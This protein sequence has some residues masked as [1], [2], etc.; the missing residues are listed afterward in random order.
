MIKEKIHVIIGGALLMSDE[1][2]VRAKF[3]DERLKFAQD[4]SFKILVGIRVLIA[5][6]NRECRGHGT[7][8]GAIFDFVATSLEESV[9]SM[10]STN[11][12]LSLSKIPFRHKAPCIHFVF[13][14]L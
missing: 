7:E 10:I 8:S 13:L 11:S 3:E 2:E 4:G 6:E 1:G 12:P 5:R 9:H 14:V